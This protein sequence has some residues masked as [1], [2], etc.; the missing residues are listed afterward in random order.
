MKNEELPDGVICQTSTTS[1]AYINGISE[2]LF[3]VGMSLPADLH[4]YDDY[5]QY[6]GENIKANIIG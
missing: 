3:K 4:D 6:I 2:K 1:V 5:V